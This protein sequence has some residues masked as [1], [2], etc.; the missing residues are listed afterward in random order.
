[1]S[2]NSLVEKIYG[3]RFDRRT[4]QYI[5]ESDELDVVSKRFLKR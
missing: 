2:I 4:I 3:A 1:M 5:E